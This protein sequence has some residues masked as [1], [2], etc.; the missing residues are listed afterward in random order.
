MR[1][2]LAQ[3]GTTTLVAAQ[4]L[5]N[6][7]TRGTAQSPVARGHNKR[8]LLQYHAEHA[9][10]PASR[11]TLL[12]K[13]DKLGLPAMRIDL[14]FDEAD[15]ELVVRSHETLAHALNASGRATLTYIVP[16][17][18]RVDSVLEQATDGYH[19]I[20]TTR[21]GDDPRSSVVD[22]D[23]KVHDLDNLYVVSS[24]V[25]CLPAKPIRHC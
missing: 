16:L 12:E 24:S 22:R 20:G 25:F 15:A 5:F 14:R 13:R 3:P 10:S 1:N 11:V 2:I 21:M 4:A 18:K 9:P 6:R 8:Y 17:E 7:V 19:Q 23:C